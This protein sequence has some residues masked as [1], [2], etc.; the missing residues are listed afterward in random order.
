[1]S[2]AA[3]PAP[4]TASAATPAIAIER[5]SKSFGG[6]QAVRD[7]SFEVPAGSVTGLIGPNGA[8][9]STLFNV[10]AGLYTPEAGR[11]R[12]FGKDVTG[13]PPHR[14]FRLG[15][16]RTFQIA[17]EFA[18]LSV[19]EN[20]M[21]VPGD[22]TGEHLWSAFLHWG[23]IKAEEARIRARA[24]QVL[25]FLKLDHLAAEEAGNLSGGQK[26]LLELGRTMMSDAKVV[27]LDEIGAGVN[28][29]LM[30]TLAGAIERLNREDGYTFCVIEHDMDLIARLC[31]PVVVMAEGTVLTE[32]TMDEVRADPRV[33]EAYLGSAAARETPAGSGS[34]AA[35]H[36]P[37]GAARP[38]PA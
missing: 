27:L 13:Q 9:K 8:G 30:S 33:I 17:H 15:L 22:Q 6:I 29:T 11:V 25:A 35:G 36:A 12:L 16:V 19:L 1:M 3:S 14:L 18:H 20:L 31:D 21:L 38:A 5:V 28:P 10:V 23:K 32:G 4:A 2:S 24:E 26:K 7:C 37:A 34:R